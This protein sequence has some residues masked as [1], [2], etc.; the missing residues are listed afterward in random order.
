MTYLDLINAVLRRLRETVVTTASE[1]DYSALVGELVNDA[2]KTVE[3]SH[4][5]TS[6]RS[7]VSFPTVVDQARYSLTGAKINSLVKRG[8]ND[9]TNKYLTQ[10]NAIWYEEKTIL[11][12]ASTGSPS[13]FIIDGVDADGLLRVSVYPTPNAIETLKFVCVIPQADLESDATQLLVPDNPVVQLAYAMA[14]RERGETGGQSAAE[15]FIVAQGA[16]AD[17]IAMDASRQPGELD[18]F[19][20]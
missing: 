7:T 16:L 11:A 1:T 17:A 19:R 14:L 13:D 15:Q 6:Q 18:F 10:R 2:K 8:M 5:W 12:T 4:E 20:L 3:N 9:T